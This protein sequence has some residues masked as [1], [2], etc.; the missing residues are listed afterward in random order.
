[1]SRGIADA[2]AAFI[3]RSSLP[4]SGRPTDSSRTTQVKLA[5]LPQTHVLLDNSELVTKRE[6]LRLQGG[7][8]SK[9]GGDQSEKGDEKRAHRGTTRIS[10]MIETS[11]FSDRTEFSVTRAYNFSRQRST[12]PSVRRVRFLPALTLFAV[13][14]RD[15]SKYRQCS[16]SPVA[17]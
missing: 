16:S 7:T 13:A 6:D 9:I 10:R 17:R 1:M 5:A 14:N 15:S 2:S 11:A 8:G 4:S 12:L 3:N